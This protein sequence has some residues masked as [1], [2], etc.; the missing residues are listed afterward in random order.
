MNQETEQ[1]DEE[2][3][4]ISPA[5]IDRNGAV[6]LSSQKA[7]LWALVLEAKSLSCRIE[8]EADGRQLLVR[9]ADL[10]AALT[11]LAA[12]EEEN[13]NWPPLPPLS[14]P[15][16]ENTLATVSALLLLAIFHN[17]TLLDLS[18]AGHAVVN[19][20]SLGN[21][22][23]ARIL[24][25]EWWRTVTA[26]TL[27]A[28]WLHLF[29]NLTIGGFFI[30]L[31]CNELGSGLSWTVLLGAGT[32]GNLVNAWCQ[33]LNHH[34][35]GASTMVFGAVGALAA[36]SMVRYRYS[37]QK[38]WGLPVAASLALLALLGT[39][40]K[41]VD[42][43]AH[44]FGFGYGVCLGI[45]AESLTARFGRPGPLFNA[46]LSLAGAALVLTA[47]WCALH[48]GFSPVH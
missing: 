38:R 12:F 10:R 4:A 19:W 24:A 16:V 27:H 41:N 32:L 20:S 26:L 43:G 29:S 30:A 31:L 6:V 25:G 21:A 7:R 9:A 1:M 40:G 35:V 44:L 33:P 48:G 39:E 15:L 47:W 17:L 13:R 23:A 46:L 14:R 8:P 45:L 36:L 5:D 3:R 11:E 42:L 2:W 18:L 28:D 37:L 22:D 34:S